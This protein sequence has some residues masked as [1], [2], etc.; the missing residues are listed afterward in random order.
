[1]EALGDHTEH[2]VE[3]S[4]TLNSTP[5]SLGGSLAERGSPPYTI[6]TTSKST[7]HLAASATEIL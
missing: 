2:L 3:G 1:M 4:R 6:S 5:V 7:E